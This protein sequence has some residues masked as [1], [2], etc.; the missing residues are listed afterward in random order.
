MHV[1]ACGSHVDVDLNQE[2]ILSPSLYLESGAL[3]LMI[4]VKLLVVGL[5]S[6]IALS[7]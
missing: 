5:R 6:Y 3:K 7:Q 4:V 2:M 1:A